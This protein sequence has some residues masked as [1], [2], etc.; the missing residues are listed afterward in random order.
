MKGEDDMLLNKVNMLITNVDMKEMQQDHSVYASVGLLS[1]DDGQ[2]FDVSV[3][4]KEIYSILIPFTTANL[5]LALMNSKYG[6]KL[7]IMGV[8]EVGQHI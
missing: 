3:R 8:N 2:K 1:M 4:D 5:N 6:L 7:N